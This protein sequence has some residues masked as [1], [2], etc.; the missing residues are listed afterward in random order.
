MRFSKALNRR[1]FLKLSVVG[2]AGTA[3]LAAC[4]GGAPA[5]APTAA[6]GGAQ[7]APTEAAAAA[8]TAAAPEPT[9]AA[10]SGTQKVTV[11]LWHP[12]GNNP[13]EGGAGPNIDLCALFE[14]QHPEVK[15][16]NVFDATWDKYLTAIAGGTP[17]DTFVLSDDQVYSLADRG[18]IMNLD[19]LIERDKLDMNAFFPCVKWQTSYNG[20]YY[21]LTHHPGVNIQWRGATAFKEA[22]LDLTKP[23][24][25]WNDVAQAAKALTK[26]EGDRFTRLGFSPTWGWPNWLSM[27]LPMNGVSILSEDG[28]KATFA[29]PEG[30][31]VIDWAMKLLED[32]YGGPQQVLAW[33]QSNLNAQQAGD[34]AY[35]V[36]PKDM[37]AM[38]F[39]GNWMCDSIKINNP[40]FES[41]VGTFPGG[42]AQQGKEFVATEGTEMGIPT[43]AKHPDYAW[44]FNKLVASEEGGYLVQAKGHDVSGNRKAAN[45]PRIVDTKYKRKEILPMFEKANINPFPVSPIAAD[46]MA[47]LDR[48]NEAFMQKQGTAEQLLK[49]AADE[50]QKALDDHYKA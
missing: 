50:V 11:S 25:N 33:A 1:E 41:W 13:D 42:P 30:I 40:S 9:K 5:A 48:T 15:M 12:W 21:A 6:Q 37:I 19:P 31:A 34:P 18:A 47:I 38:T 20:H 10:V 28:R 17:P 45:D 27:F 3:L 29:T 44:E 16:E 2:V 24:A 22:G 32:C 39:Y 4:G 46:I 26:K 23:F 14:K 43:Q 8:P 49:N 35:F 36:F 7:A